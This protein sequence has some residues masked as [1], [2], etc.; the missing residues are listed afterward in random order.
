LLIIKVKVK[1]DMQPEY[2]VAIFFIISGACYWYGQKMDNWR[3][4]I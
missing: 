3:C 4:H 1:N 2:P